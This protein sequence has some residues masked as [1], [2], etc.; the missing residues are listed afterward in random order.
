MEK[1]EGYVSL[2]S[3]RF[4]PPQ[5][6]TMGRLVLSELEKGSTD[7]ALAVVPMMLERLVALEKYADE[8]GKVTVTS[9]VQATLK[10]G[11]L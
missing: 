3:I 2:G 5:W 7:Y 4:R 8:D 6:E 11:G 10:K 1:E 9:V